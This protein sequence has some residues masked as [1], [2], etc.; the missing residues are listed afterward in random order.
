IIYTAKPKILPKFRG[1]LLKIRPRL[2]T[3]R[4]PRSSPAKTGPRFGVRA[5]PEQS[6]RL[7]VVARYAPTAPPRPPSISLRPETRESIRRGNFRHTSQRGGAERRPSGHAP[8]IM[9]GDGEGFGSPV[10]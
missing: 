1:Q 10:R 4:L 6:S 2:V 9:Y 3:L 8:G 5:H 7:K